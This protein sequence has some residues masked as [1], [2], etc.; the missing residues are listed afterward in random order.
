[1]NDDLRSLVI[2][3]LYKEQDT[4]YEMDGI[5]ELTEGQ[6]QN[7]ANQK[8]KSID[9]KYV[10]LENHYDVVNLENL[11]DNIIQ[12]F[13]GQ[14]IEVKPI[15]SI[16]KHGHTIEWKNIF[17][18]SLEHITPDNHKESWKTVAFAINKDLDIDGMKMDYILKLKDFIWSDDKKLDKSAEFRKIF[19]QDPEKEKLYENMI[20]D[21][22]EDLEDSLKSI[23]NDD[24]YYLSG[25][26]FSN[27]M[28]FYDI[29]ILILRNPVLANKGKGGSNYATYYRKDKK[30]N[31]IILVSYKPSIRKRV[32][33]NQTDRFYKNLLIYD[34]NEED[35]DKKYKPYVTTEYLTKVNH[36]WFDLFS[37]E[38]TKPTN[39]NGA[40]RVIKK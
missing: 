22:E 4:Y 10:Q 40:I 19:K 1:M 21:D 3:N 28:R 8:L 25:F 15:Y 16:Q 2:N 14:T 26:D 5:I 27:I 36:K 20:L 38:E 13:Y 17:P 24:K 32:T 31:T 29:N 9:S 7:L 34:I 35:D 18:G 33:T 39:K 6:L 37:K 30:Y 23:I 11:K 12:T